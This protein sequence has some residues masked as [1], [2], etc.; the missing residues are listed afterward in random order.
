M[1][2]TKQRRRWTKEEIEK[3][4]ELSNKYTKSD[5]AKKMNR[6]VGS[7]NGKLNAL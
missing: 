4:E 6:S 5:I 1:E 2:K 7:V 3:L